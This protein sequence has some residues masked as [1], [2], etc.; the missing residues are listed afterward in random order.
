MARARE[1]NA[2]EML[3]QPPPIIESS[4]VD[5]EVVTK[6]DMDAVELEQFMNEP[7][8][9]RI[10]ESNDEN[11]TEYVQVA[12]NGRGLLLPRAQPLWVKRMYVE[13]LARAKRTS[14]AQDMKRMDESLNVLTRKT[15]LDYP[16]S[17]L[18]DSD[19]GR[20][21]LEGVMADSA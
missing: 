7:V 8:L 4:D 16:F 20:A 14:I 3:H 21:W 19:R 5:I 1:V 6:L 12:V 17:V 10:S 15:G 9:I 13:R 2:E 11:A 18:K